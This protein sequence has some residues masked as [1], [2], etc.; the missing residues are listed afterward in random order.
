[1]KRFCTN[2]LYYQDLSDLSQADQKL[3]IESAKLSLQRHPESSEHY[4]NAYVALTYLTNQPFTTKFFTYTIKQPFTSENKRDVEKFI[5]SKK[6]LKDAFIYVGM[7]IPEHFT[8]DIQKDFISLTKAIVGNYNVCSVRRYLFNYSLK[9]IQKVYPNFPPLT[10]GLL[11]DGLVNV[12]AKPGRKLL[13]SSFRRERLFPELQ[14]RMRE[15]IDNAKKGVHD[16]VF[17]T[18]GLFLESTSYLRLKDVF[19]H[20]V[21]CLLDFREYKKHNKARLFIFDSSYSQ[22][23]LMRHKM[24]YNLGRSVEFD[25][26]HNFNLDIHIMPMETD[27]CYNLQGTVGTCLLWTLFVGYLYILNPNMKIILS[28]LEKMSQPERDKLIAY[29]LYYSQKHVNVIKDI[30][31]TYMQNRKVKRFPD[32]TFSS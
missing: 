32:V 21:L 4:K 27:V 20:S 30:S 10:Y 23:D 8:T 19:L 13:K 17:Y 26:Q 15:C 28:T 31:K 5:K 22:K 7:K 18:V 14:Q 6:Y 3:V 1:M 25:L 12:L 2:R 29:F 16:F 9:Q 11:P 24:L